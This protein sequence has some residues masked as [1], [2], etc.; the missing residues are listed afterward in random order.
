VA[1]LGTVPVNPVITVAGG[2][3]GLWWTQ[4]STG[5]FRCA[6]DSTGSYPYTPLYTLKSIRKK[7]ILNRESPVPDPEG[8]D[9]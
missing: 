2:I 1:L 4:H 6:G 8:D 5:V 3:D 7:G 9:L